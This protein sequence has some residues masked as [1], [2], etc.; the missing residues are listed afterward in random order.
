MSGCNKERAV[1]VSSNRLLAVP[2]GL[3][4]STR[5]TTLVQTQNA[6]LS[7]VRDHGFAPGDFIR[8]VIATLNENV[9]K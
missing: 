8:L 4:E 7:A 2:D 1:R 5:G 9:G 6:N 3:D